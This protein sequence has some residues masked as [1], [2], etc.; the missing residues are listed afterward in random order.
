MK[1]YLVALIVSLAVPAGAAVSP[2]AWDWAFGDGCAPVVKQLPACTGQPA[3]AKSCSVQCFTC[4]ATAT[5]PFVQWGAQGACDVVLGTV[6]Q[7]SAAAYSAATDLF[8]NTLQQGI[9]AWGEE[10]QKQQAAGWASTLVTLLQT[11]FNDELSLQTTLGEMRALWAAVVKSDQ[12]LTGALINRVISSPARQQFWQNVLA[13]VHGTTGSAGPSVLV[14]ALK[15]ANVITGPCKAFVA[16]GSSSTFYQPA[17]RNDCGKSF[18]RPGP[19]PFGPGGGLYDPT[20][21]GDFCS[22]GRNFPPGT[23]AF[24][25]GPTGTGPGANPPGIGPDAGPNGVDPRITN[26]DG[27]DPSGGCG[28]GGGGPTGAAS[29]CM[30]QV[31]NASCYGKD[32]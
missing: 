13:Q 23:N 17:C 5:D 32:F 11:G 15:I 9:Q 10:S 2:T 3:D 7:S 14:E 20:D 24:G 25:N 12:Q 18:G 1:R 27:Y 28:G 8:V 6:T 31:N 19:G 29:E 26:P 4:C 16:S 21:P 30:V 22:S